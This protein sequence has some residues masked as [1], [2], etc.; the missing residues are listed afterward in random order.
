MFFHLRCPEGGPLP[1]RDVA[2]DAV[3]QKKE[4]KK[5]IKKLFITYKILQYF[6]SF[7]EHKRLVHD[8]RRHLL[9]KNLTL[10]HNFHYRYLLS[11]D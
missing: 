5:Y 9:Q 6:R 2:C 1:R 10:A 8:Y 7:S 4:E 3:E 11:S